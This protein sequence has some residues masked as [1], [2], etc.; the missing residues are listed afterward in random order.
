MFDS[1]TPRQKKRDIKLAERRRVR[2]QL[3]KMNYFSS[4]KNDGMTNNE[5]HHSQRMR[6]ELQK[7]GP[8][9]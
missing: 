2:K 1:R 3:K 9:N 6:R 8:S 4:R 5:R 7:Y